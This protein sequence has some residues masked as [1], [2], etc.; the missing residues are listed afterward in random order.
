MMTG[1]T[2]TTMTRDRLKLQVLNPQAEWKTVYVLV[3]L[4]NI[5]IALL[6]AYGI[7]FRVV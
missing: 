1:M 5:N 2:M 3:D 6:R 4:L 7:K